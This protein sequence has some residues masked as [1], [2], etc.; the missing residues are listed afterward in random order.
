MSPTWTVVLVWLFL[1]GFAGYLL[2]GFDKSRARSGGW[3]IPEKTFL[4]LALIGG[5]F[6]VL[7]G[8][9]VF[10][11]KTRKSPFIEVIFLLAIGWIVLLFELQRVLGPFSA[12]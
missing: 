7:A 12:L 2:M 8:S 10:H 1:C 11:H 5:S 6:G 4:T 9:S 3:R